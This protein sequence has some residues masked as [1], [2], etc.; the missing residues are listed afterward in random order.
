MLILVIAEWGAGE[1]TMALA[2][3]ANGYEPKPIETTRVL[4]SV[5]R[6]LSLKTVEVE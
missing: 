2:Q 6:L 1:A 3:G 5:A 4:A